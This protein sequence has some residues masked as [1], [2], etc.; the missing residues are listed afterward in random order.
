MRFPDCSDVC[1]DGSVLTPGA[2]SRAIADRITGLVHCSGGGLIKSKSFGS[3]LHFVKD[4]LFEM[5]HLFQMIRSTG[6]VAD[7]EMY[8]VF[9]MGHRLEIYREPRAAQPVI[10][11]ATQLGVEAR[12]IGE[13]LR[14]SGDPNEV[15][16]VAEGKTYG[17][18]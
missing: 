16:V 5:P 9:N 15:S 13:I 6:R 11:Y 18:R 7:G 12:V 2:H 3:G 1:A 10:D 8:K 17:Y 14:A 4:R